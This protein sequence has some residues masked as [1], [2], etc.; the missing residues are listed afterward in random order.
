MSIAGVRAAG[1]LHR[2]WVADVDTAAV[3]VDHYWVDRPSSVCGTRRISADSSFREFLVEFE[4]GTNL[5]MNGDPALWMSNASHRDDVT[6][7]SPFGHQARGLSQVSTQY[8]GAAMQFVPSNVKASFDY[9]AIGVDGNL[10]YTVIVQQATVRRVGQPEPVPAYTRA[11]NIF[12][13]ERCE[14]RLIHRHM[15]NVKIPS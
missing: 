2:H 13:R 15:D 4:A 14:W 10:A 9:L 3:A 11:T 7:L 5:F 1:I 12:R 8:R 6:L